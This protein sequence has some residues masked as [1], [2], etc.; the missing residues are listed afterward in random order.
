M[1]RG[2]M[3]GSRPAEGRAVDPEGLARERTDEKGGRDEREPAQD[4]GVEEAES[5]LVESADD[6]VDSHDDCPCCECEMNP[7]CHPPQRGLS[8]FGLTVVSIFIVFRSS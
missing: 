7:S 6:G 2:S 1:V 5:D 4:G 3:F 8:G